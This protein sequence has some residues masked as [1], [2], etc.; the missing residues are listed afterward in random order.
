MRYS[1]SL[2]VYFAPVRISHM[3][4]SRTDKRTPTNPLRPNIF[5]EASPL[6][7]TETAGT[8]LFGS[9]S[10]YTVIALH[11]KKCSQPKPS[12]P[13]QVLL[14]QDFA[15]RPTFPIAAFLRNLGLVSVPLWL[16]TLPDQR[17][18]TPTDGRRNSPGVGAHTPRHVPQATVWVLIPRVPCKRSLIT[19]RADG[20]NRRRLLLCASYTAEGPRSFPSVGSSLTLREIEFQTRCD[21]LHPMVHHWISPSELMQH[22]ED[23]VLCKGGAR[24]GSF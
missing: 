19:L 23:K 8:K 5:D 14:E 15:H 21:E 24:N 6:G 16:I 3:I 7:M 13:R 12:I 20:C 9:Y 17:S 22:Q 1:S 4:Q 11:Y 18:S 2:D 10:Q